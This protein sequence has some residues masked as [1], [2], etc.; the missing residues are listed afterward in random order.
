[1]KK[2]LFLFLVVGFIYAC[3]KDKI[4]TRP[5]LSFKSYSIDSVT[6][7]TND[8]VVTMNVEDGDG[9]IEDTLLIAPL[10]KSHQGSDTL[11]VG[12]K[13]PNIGGNNGNRI[14]GEIQIQLKS[15]D[16]RV[17]SDPTMPKDSIHFVVFIRDNAGH[18]SDTVS[19][20]KIPYR[21]Q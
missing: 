15:I 1:M 10:I 18:F 11:W 7:A 20:P 5:I 19:T 8:M 6:P 17:S 21:A 9:D 2:I 4:G 12:R 16:F 14:K 3:N 13:M